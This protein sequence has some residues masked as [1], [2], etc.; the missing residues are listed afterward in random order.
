M[1]YLNKKQAKRLFD[2]YLNKEC[3]P[4]ERQL[5]ESY[6]ESHQEG[7]IDWSSTDFKMEVEEQLWKKIKAQTTDKNTPKVKPLYRRNWIKYAAVFVGAVFAAIAYVQYSGGKGESLDIKEEMVV[8]QTDM[9]QDKPLDDN[10]TGEVKDKSGKVIASLQGGVLKYKKENNSLT[11]PVFNEI[12]VPLGKTFKLVLSDGTLVHLNAGTHLRFPV[13][14]RSEGNREVFLSGE[15]Y[16]EVAKNE[17][18]PFIVKADAMEVT[19]LGTHF[20]VSSYGGETQHTVLV[21]G[22]VSV[23][24]QN[25]AAAQGSQIIRPGQ[26]A[27]MVPDG[28]KVDEVDVE[29]YIGWTQNILVFK[30]ELFPEIIQKIERKYNVEIENNY[31][32]LDT[33]RF[34]GKFGDESIISLMN[35]FK[36]SANFDYEIQ[37]GKILI[38]KK[39]NRL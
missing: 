33:A 14:F 10:T 3:T 15:A 35:T 13:G 32:E 2:K 36:E 39:N 26:K 34:N 27:I 18:S 23:N 19:V 16:F 5:V 37:D 8:L 7:S 12:D 20:N 6:L 1:K 25:M 22:S 17:S 28:L 11:E 9:G 21:E 24:N 31:I 4:E 38:N 30:D 29:D